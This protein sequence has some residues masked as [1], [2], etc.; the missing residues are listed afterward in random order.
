[1]QQLS[2]ASIVAVM[3]D[4]AVAPAPDPAPVASTISFG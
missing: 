2:A 4:V 1:M 3:V